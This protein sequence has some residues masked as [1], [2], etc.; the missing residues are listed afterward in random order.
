VTSCRHTNADVG[1]RFQF[2]TISEPQGR[3][4]VQARV[5]RARAARH[6][7]STSPSSSPLSS[8]PRT[9]KSVAKGHS[10]NGQVVDGV[11][12]MDAVSPADHV[13]TDLQALHPE[14]M[15]AAVQARVQRA[16]AAASAAMPRPSSWPDLSPGRIRSPLRLDSIRPGSALAATTM[17]A[18]LEVECDEGEEA[19]L[20]REMQRYMQEIYDKPMKT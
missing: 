12:T 1:L 17:S 9:A 11:A 19:E 14:T 18:S 15:E 3:V 20:D 7:S 4:A 5:E 8:P 16:R 10:A 2:S 13:G 6:Q